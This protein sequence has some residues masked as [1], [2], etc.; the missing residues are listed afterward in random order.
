MTENSC[1]HVVLVFC[2]EIGVDFYACDHGCLIYLR[3]IYTHTPHS[4]DCDFIV[5]NLVILL[6]IFIKHTS[7][8]TQYMKKSRGHFLN[9]LNEYGVFT[10]QF[11]QSST[12]YL[13]AMLST[14][15]LAY[16]N[17]SVFWYIHYGVN[18]SK[19]RPF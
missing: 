15:A 12:F 17:Q 5:S 14:L 8:I 13:L 7:I 10:N 3:D 2:F 9:I 6:N 11:I 19:L 4:K 18:H 16:L 1:D